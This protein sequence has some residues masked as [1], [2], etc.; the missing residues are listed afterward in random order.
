MG[1]GFGG[2]NGKADAAN[3][4]KQNGDE[5]ESCGSPRD[6]C[7]GTRSW[8]SHWSVERRREGFESPPSVEG[9]TGRGWIETSG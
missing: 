5:G 6:E 4:D 1:S 8:A 9:M 2:V 3:V 7:D